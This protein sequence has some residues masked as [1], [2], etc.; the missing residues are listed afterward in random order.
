MSIQD[1]VDISGNEKWKVNLA[2]IITDANFLSRDIKYHKNCHTANWCKYIQAKERISNRE[3]SAQADITVQFISAEIEFIAELQDSLDQG[4]ILTLSEV[5]TQYNNMMCDHGVRNQQ[6]TRAVLL[7]KI[8]EQIL[9][10]SS[11]F[12]Q[13][14]CSHRL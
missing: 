1:I 6:I 14:A 7:T 12:D 5:A 3:P 9:L 4:N 2:H 10:A 13:L 8:E 11:N